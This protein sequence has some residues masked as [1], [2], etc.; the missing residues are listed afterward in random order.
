M[1]SRELFGKCRAFG[2]GASSLR[3]N[4]WERIWKTS[5]TNIISLLVI[6]G[7]KT[8]E[9]KGISAAGATKESRRYTAVADAELLLKGP[10]FPRE[11]PLPS[12]PA[13]VSPALISHVASELIA[14]K[15]EVIGAGLFQIPSFPYIA[16]DTPSLGPSECVTTGKAMSPKRVDAL[17][18]LS[19]IHI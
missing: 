18:N 6:A 15:T 12:L 16:F 9:I 14:L 7:S 10:S 11:C 8:A 1:F 3:L 2:L 5:T 13:G 4:R 19:L 17:M